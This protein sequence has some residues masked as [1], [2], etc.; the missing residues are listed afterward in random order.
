MRYQVE[1]KFEKIVMFETHPL[2]MST[3]SEELIS[4]RKKSKPFNLKKE[5]TLYMQGLESKSLFF[6][7]SGYIK[8][9]K[10][11][12][13]GRVFIL[14]VVEPGEFFG[15]LTLAGE[16]E[17]STG[18]D[19]MDDCS[20]IE[21]KKETFEAF[22]K[23]RPDLAIKLVQVIGDKRLSMENMLRDMIFMDIETRIASLLLK[24]ADGDMLKISLTHQEI[25]DMTGST[26]VSVSRT[27]IKFR[28]KGLIETSCERIKLKNI[29]KLSEYQQK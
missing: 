20:G 8:L 29:E 23:S 1:N 16:N 7:E 9:S 27:I 25:A 19:A 17:R 13:D 10:I 2:F 6:L 21:I 11:N 15:E 4:L 24:Y 28:N 14:D 22:L 18:A 26:R 3:S 5:Q 12:H